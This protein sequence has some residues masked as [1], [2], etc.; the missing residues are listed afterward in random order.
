MGFEEEDVVK[1]F[2]NRLGD[3]LKDIRYIIHANECI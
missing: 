2:S 3:I 1:M